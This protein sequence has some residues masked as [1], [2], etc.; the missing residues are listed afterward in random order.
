MVSEDVVT[1]R[2]KPLTYKAVLFGSANRP[3]VSVPMAVALASD[4]DD[5]DYDVV[6]V[7][8]EDADLVAEVM[9][10]D[11]DLEVPS[12][13]DDSDDDD[14]PSD[15]DDLVAPV[16]AEEGLSSGDEDEDDDDDLSVSEPGE[17]RA[18]IPTESPTPS[19]KDPKAEPRLSIFDPIH[20][21]REM[22]KQLILLE[23]HLAHPSKFCPDCIRKHLLASEA[24]AEEAITLDKDGKHKDLLG[25]L[26]MEVRGI[27]KSFVE[28]Q[29]REKLV[30]RCR[31]LRKRLSKASYASIAGAAPKSPPSSPSE[32]G[33][34]RAAPASSGAAAASLTPEIFKM[35]KSDLKGRGVFGVGRGAGG[36]I[37]VYAS[38]SATVPS[39]Y[40]GVPVVKVVADKPR[41]QG[42]LGSKNRFGVDYTAD[43][44]PGTPVLYSKSEG[45]KTLWRRGLL[46]AGV[47]QPNAEGRYLVV[48]SGVRSMVPGD[49]I[50][51]AP[52][53]PISTLLRGK[54]V[55]RFDLEGKPFPTYK[56]T[57]DQLVVADGIQSVFEAN[58]VDVCQD[59][60]ISFGFSLGEDNPASV[61]LRKQA[62][63]MAIP[64]KVLAGA[65]VNAIYESNLN[66]NAVAP[67]EPSV[68]LWQLNSNGAGAGMSVED[69]KDLR[70]GTERI[71]EEMKSRA[72]DSSLFRALVARDIASASANTPQVAPRVSEYAAFWTIEVERPARAQDAA[73]SRSRTA[74]DLFP[75]PSAQKPFEA[76]SE[77]VETV[78]EKAEATLLPA[79]PNAPE[80]SLS[81][82]AE[83]EGW[84]GLAIAGGALLV[85]G[86]TGIAMAATGRGLSLGSGNIPGPYARSGGLASFNIDEDGDD[87]DLGPLGGF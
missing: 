46:V 50:L 15:D 52:R 37:V 40:R 44:K 61:A 76:V 43:L 55:K 7:G 56:L 29:D 48:D 17:V 65:I 87:I 3:Q 57:E 1:A 49:S 60:G 72:S 75:G 79:A 32:A 42:T 19:P 6:S 20:N 85:A 2:R 9:G 80:R 67:N 28:E 69:R 59:L 33:Q 53:R 22:S 66:P 35:A 39:S 45:G 10:A 23:D 78:K 41:L 63:R 58:L 84:S 18:D 27:G 62:C 26:P 5:D 64:G 51:R 36:K 21:V 82:P 12:S 83:D 34:S 16:M 31:S 81:R 14:V 4:F 11:E 70:K 71:L 73:K 77:A 47:P 24:L 13:F 8:D 86:L 54:L 68:G 30:Q 74:E 25:A 38:S